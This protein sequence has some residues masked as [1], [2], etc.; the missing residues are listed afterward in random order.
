MR[1][2]YLGRSGTKVSE[3]C[4]GAMTFGREAD[5]ATSHRMLEEFAERG[6]NFI[7]TADVYGPGT[8]EEV[9]GRWLRHQDR[10]Q[11]VIATKVRFPSGPVANDDRVGTPTGRAGRGA[12]RHPLGPAAR[13]LAQWPLHPPDARSASRIPRG[14]RRAT[15][16]E[17]NLG[18]H[19]R[20]PASETG[21]STGSVRPFRTRHT[22][23]RSTTT[24]QRE[25]RP[26]KVA[27][28]GTR[29]LLQPESTAAQRESAITCSG[30][31]TY[32][33]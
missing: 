26:S 6:G 22:E 16:L 18:C 5:E 13:R 10:D 9:T 31:R 4:L 20:N 14:H 15:G 28:T 23:R 32:W 1:Y 29:M 7:D 17:R 30:V 3:V 24:D 2:R 21:P 8:S 27:T 33:P 25:R 11:W 12:G 19:G